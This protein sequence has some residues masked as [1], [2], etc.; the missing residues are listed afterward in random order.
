MLNN[1]D[2]KTLI[3]LF[4]YR[5]P[6]KEDYPQTKKGPTNLKVSFQSWL[7]FLYGFL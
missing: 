1:Q 2:P 5:N 7:Y 3:L 4:I 6:D